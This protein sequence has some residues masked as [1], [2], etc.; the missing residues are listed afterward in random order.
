MTQ[1]SIAIS[2]TPPLPGV[3]LVEQA[4]GALETIAT[5]FAGTTDPASFAG[6]Y[7]TW[8]D[9][10]TGTLWRRNAAGSAWVEIGR[11]LD[12]SFYSADI[13][14]TAQAQ[15]LTSDLVLLTP[16]KLDDAFMGAN[17]GL[18]SNSY[19]QKHPG[20]LLEQGGNVFATT[21]D[22]LLTFPVAFNVAPISV[23]ASAVGNVAAFIG[24]MVDSSTSTNVALRIRNA[25][26][27]VGGMGVNWKATG[28][29]K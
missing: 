18:A 15:A 12:R 19:F 22:F 28:Y 25:T 2:T 27:A 29:W 13:A 7:M 24:V 16:K 5:D 23:V 20:G 10:G 8:A 4:N 14:S 6:P 21:A 3:Q 11:V 1:A 26:G 9:T 17:Q